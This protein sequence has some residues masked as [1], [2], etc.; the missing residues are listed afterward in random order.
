MKLQKEKLRKRSIYNCIKN[1]K[2]SR[3]KLNQ[4]G[5]RSTKIDEM[6]TTKIDEDGTK[7]WNGI[8]CSWIGQ[9]IF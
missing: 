4:W 2:T 8:Q 1:N 6:K 5:E 9:T 7:K 3:N